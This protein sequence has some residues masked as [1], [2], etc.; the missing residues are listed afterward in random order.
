MPERFDLVVVGFGGAGA[1]AA[2]TAHDAGARVLLLE[3]QERGA[4]TPSTRMSGGLVMVAGDPDAATDYFDAC[5]GGMVPREVCAAWARGAVELEGWL[6]EVTGLSF[7]RIATAEHP[8]LP[9]AS[10]VEVCQPGSAAHRLDPAAGSGESVFAALRA[11]VERRGIEVR[12]SSPAER[13]VTE[14]GR[15][16]GVRTPH[17]LVSARHGV[18]LTCGGYEFDERAKQD[19]LRAYPVHFYGNPGNTG[20]GLRMAQAVGA[21]LWHMNQ[22]VGR[23]IGHFPLGEEW[24]NVIIDISPAPYL[25]T[26][27]D[28]RRYAD[29]T[30]QAQL[31][32]GFYYAMLDYD[33]ERAVHPRI[34]SYWLFD[35]R[36]RTAGPLT[37][38]HIGACRVGMYDWSPDNSAEITRGWIG[39]G[40]TPGEA[41]A[42]VGMSDPAAMDRAVAD[43]D[44]ACAA[45]TDPLGRQPD[46]LVPLEPPYYCVPLYPGGSNTSGG[47]RR[48][49][50]AR[51]LDPF[52]DPIP[53]LFAAGELGQPVGMLYPADGANLSEAFCFGRIA[54]TT[55]LRGTP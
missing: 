32:H 1:A 25:I 16:V 45:G 9:G 11:A 23:A 51:V 33:Y 34:P 26:D 3:K 49:A 46:T 43:Y 10:T 17:G 18:L 5:A 37:L 54:A 40:A 19:H 13:L 4:H 31:L 47:P 35:E 20:D 44:T 38:T 6:A 2:V 48:D 29:E 39:R 8:Q 55:A 50:A 15:V 36:R 12:Y 24:L 41:A 30:M 7:S 28:G 52:D 53:G 22:M 21:D 14:D 27:G 42:A